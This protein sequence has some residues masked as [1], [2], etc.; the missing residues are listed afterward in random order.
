MVESKI[1]KKNS[2]QEIEP[3]NHAFY[4]K[5]NKVLILFI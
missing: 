5:T 4:A 2:K 3:A 1:M